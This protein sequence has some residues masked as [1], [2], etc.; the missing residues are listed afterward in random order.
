MERSGLNTSKDVDGYKLEFYRKTLVA[1]IIKTVIFLIAWSIESSIYDAAK[2]LQEIDELKELKN[3]A[4]ANFLEV[5]DV[6]FKALSLSKLLLIAGYY[7]FPCLMR[8]AMLV[9]GLIL[10]THAFIPFITNFQ[11][12]ITIFI[13]ITDFAVNYCGDFIVQI[14]FANL[15]LMGVNATTL[16]KNSNEKE[17]LEPN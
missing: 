2:I 6:I 3:T 10:L 7:K 9:D 11:L 1:T 4:H 14:I 8:G 16:A 12:Y 13:A 15:V 17:V 5:Q